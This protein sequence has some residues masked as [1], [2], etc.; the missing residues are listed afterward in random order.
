MGKTIPRLFKRETHVKE[1]MYGYS[2]IHILKYLACQECNHHSTKN[3][4]SKTSG[5]KNKVSPIITFQTKITKM[6]NMEKMT[7]DEEEWENK[8]NIDSLT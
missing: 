7:R 6:S 1:F 2:Q 5:H 4:D 8:F 3:F